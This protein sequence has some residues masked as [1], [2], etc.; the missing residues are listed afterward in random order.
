M[1]GQC[2][3]LFTNESK[4]KITKFFASYQEDDYPRGGSIVEENIVI[5]QGTFL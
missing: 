3:L 5:P 2:G 1:S 4:E